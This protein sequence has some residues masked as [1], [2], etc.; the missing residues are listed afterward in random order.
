MTK[1]KTDKRTLLV[2]KPLL[3]DLSGDQ[4]ESV[5]GSIAYGDPPPKQPPEPGIVAVASAAPR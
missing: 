1:S 4:L 5:C 2:A 3:R